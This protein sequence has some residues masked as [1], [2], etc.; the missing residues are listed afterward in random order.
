ML[1][2]GSWIFLSHSSHDIEKVRMVR[3]E[4]ERLGHNPLAFHLKCLSDKT[5]KDKQELL[6]LIKREIDARQWFV[7]CESPAAKE[8]PYVKFERDYINDSGKDKIWSLDMT[9]ENDKIKKLVETISTDI[10]VF[11][12]YLH[13]DA[14]LI[15][16]LIKALVEK[17]YSVWTPETKLKSGDLFIQKVS[18]AIIHC[19]YKGFFLLVITQ[20]SVK[21]DF[22]KKELDFA[23]LH[24]AFIIPLIIGNPIIPEESR[25][26]NNL[27]QIHIKT[28]TINYVLTE[29]DCNYILDSIDKLVKQ[30]TNKFNSIL[31][32]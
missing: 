32:H 22:V 29:N 2:G 6:S 14:E 8:S 1:N 13:S 19:S 17:D 12:S 3:N 26:I 5:E 15:Q 16:P 4:F 28:N 11:I 30:K 25:Y 10:E 18:E 9:Q 23:L 31:E 27:Q 7:F 24:N 20:N 21:S